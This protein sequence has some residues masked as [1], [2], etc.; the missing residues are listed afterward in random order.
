MLGAI[1]QAKAEDIS[2]AQACPRSIMNR[3]LA[4][5]KGKISK[6]GSLSWKG[7]QDDGDWH[8]NTGLGAK[9]GGASLKRIREG[10]AFS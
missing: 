9:T 3:A 10:V 8:T 4:Q 1:L 2:H 7:T 6:K 5:A